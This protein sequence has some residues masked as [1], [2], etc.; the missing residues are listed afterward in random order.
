MSK[1]MTAAEVEK[2]LLPKLQGFK[3]EAAQV[4]DAHAKARQAIKDNPRLSAEAKKD[5][6]AA[7][8]KD[9]SAKLASIKDEQQ[10]YVDNLRATLEQQF[11]G[12]LPTDAASVVS[13]RDA[14]DRARKLDRKEAMEVLQDAIAGNDA[15]FAHAIGTRARNY[16]WEDVADAYMAAHPDTADSAAALSWVEDNTSGGAYNLSNSITFSAPTD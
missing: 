9:T 4:K 13:R 5:D 15:D 16:G 14:A 3:D 6:L 1:K 10:R 12:S 7:L 8:V 2:T 11:R